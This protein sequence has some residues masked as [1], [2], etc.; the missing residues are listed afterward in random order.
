M[1]EN[2]QDKLHA[3]SKKFTFVGLNDS[4]T[5]W[6]YYNAGLRQVLMSR[7]VIFS[8]AAPLMDEPDL[9]E[10][11]IAMPKVPPAETAEGKV[12][13]IKLP[14]AT[15]LCTICSSSCNVQHIDY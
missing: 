5:A 14:A 4:S 9:E 6:R 7:S 3:K 12:E 8:R 2:W 10:D 11:D 13:P 15:I 1:P